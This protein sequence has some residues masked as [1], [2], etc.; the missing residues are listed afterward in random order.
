M[1]AVEDVPLG[2]VTVIATVPVP[3]GAVAMMDES[4]VTPKLVAAVVPKSTALAPENPEPLMVTR[5]PPVG[6]PKL[7]LM[8][9]T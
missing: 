3:D 7:G 2:V 1:L 8:L 5:V 9:L 6:G 4:A